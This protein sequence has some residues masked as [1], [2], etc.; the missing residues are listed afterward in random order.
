[1]ADE[2]RTPPDWAVKIGHAE[3]WKLHKRLALLYDAPGENN[4]SVASAM[5][6]DSQ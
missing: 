5:M 3:M 4:S 1:V 6:P 2:Q